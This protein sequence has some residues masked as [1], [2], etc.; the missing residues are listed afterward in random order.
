MLAEMPES[1]PSAAKVISI[2]KNELKFDYINDG[3]IDPFI[4]SKN[5]R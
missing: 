1:R 4:F 2:L 5:G 3:H